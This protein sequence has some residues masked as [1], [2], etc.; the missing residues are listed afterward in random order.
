MTTVVKIPQK[1]FN[2]D[3]PPVETGGC[4]I[5]MLGSGR[6]GKTTA[7][8]YCIDRFFKQHLG[9]I[10]SQ[11]AKATA[12]QDM[13]YPLLPLSSVFIPELMNDAYH[14]NKETKNHYP[15]LSC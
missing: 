1:S 5:L 6:S 8:K 2:L 15:F 13:N 4:S 14:I 10:F 7:L 11:S 12:Y 3:M 9:V